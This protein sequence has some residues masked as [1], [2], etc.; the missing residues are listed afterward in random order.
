MFVS[1]LIPCYNARPW[2]AQAIESALVQTWP[3]KEVIV[4]DDGSTDGSLDVI[5][6]FGSAIR[7][8]T[9]PNRGGNVAR[10]RLLDLAQGE[11][12]QYLDADDCLLPQKIERQFGELDPLTCDVAISPVILL[13]CEGDR[14]P[15]E[16]FRA[17]PEPHDLWVNLVRME[18]PQTAA[19]L[20]R[21]SAL[22]DVGRWKP[23]QPCCQELELYF[24]LLTAG[25]RFQYCPTAGVLYRQWSTQ[26]V[27]R[28]DPM[29]TLGRWLAIIEA[30]ERHLQQT[31]ELSEPRRDAIALSRLRCARSIYQ[32]EP[33]R[34]R[35]VAELAKRSHPRFSLLGSNDFPRAYRWAHQLGGFG[36]AE[37]VAELVRPLKRKPD[38][39]A[40]SPQPRAVGSHRSSAEPASKTASASG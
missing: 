1:I 34:A 6:S 22:I 7:V 19:P 17:I 10:N 16:E 37:R 31:G 27:W 12:L 21:K 9:G 18:L 15:W 30:A 35:E 32:Y 2:V 39:S 13:H 11:W 20:W 38:L 4:V 25:K 36:F 28:K 26:T 33:N 23:D 40:T 3:D 8:E 29:L 14:E 24:R 5:R